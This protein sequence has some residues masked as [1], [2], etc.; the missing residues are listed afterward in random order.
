MEQ[1][2]QDSSIN[3]PIPNQGGGQQTGRG[4]LWWLLLLLLLPLAIWGIVVLV[5]SSNSNDKSSPSAKTSP[6]SSPSTSSSPSPVALKE[7][8]DV[9]KHGTASC[10]KMSTKGDC[11]SRYEYVDGVQGSDGISHVCKWESGKCNDKGAQCI[12]SAAPSSYALSDCDDDDKYPGTIGGVDRCSKFTGYKSKCNKHYHYYKGVKG[13]RGD[14]NRCR[15]QDG[16]CSASGGE[17]CRIGD[18]DYSS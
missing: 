3:T 16:K 8:S 10:N 15:Y 11:E 7:C 9:R 5:R 18:Y 13:A 4:K 6:S 1:Q 2:T 14:S 17:A 12:V